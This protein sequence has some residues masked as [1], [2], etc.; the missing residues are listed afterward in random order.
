VHDA[1]HAIN[2][3]RI[4]GLPNFSLSSGRIPFGVKIATIEKP[5]PEIPANANVFVVANKPRRSDIDLKFKLRFAGS[6]EEA[7]V[8]LVQQIN[9]TRIVD[10]QTN[11]QAADLD[12]H[13]GTFGSNQSFRHCGPLDQL[14]Y[15]EETRT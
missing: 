2:G 15:R 6:G 9:K 12:D 4:D 8:A 1:Q 7:F 13:L 11:R 14:R 10:A 3:I 5:I